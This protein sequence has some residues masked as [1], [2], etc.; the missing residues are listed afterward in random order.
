ML[1]ANTGTPCFASSIAPK[2]ID[3]S[4]PPRT[5]KS[6]RKSKIRNYVFD[7]IYYLKN[8]S[9]SFKNCLPAIKHLCRKLFSLVPIIFNDSWKICFSLIG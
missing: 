3:F 5:S 8:D 1:L 2:G 4:K 7:N 6:E 9:R